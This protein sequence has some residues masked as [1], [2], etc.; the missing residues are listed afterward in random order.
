MAPAATL[1]SLLLLLLQMIPSQMLSKL[2]DFKTCGDPECARYLSRVTA[3]LDYT[4][5]DCRFLTFKHGDSIYVYFKLSG[6]RDDLWAGSIGK[7]FGYFPK[8][9]VKVDDVMTSTEVELPTQESDFLC[10]DEDNYHV[11]SEE[12]DVVIDEYG[13]NS[14]SRPEERESIL[15]HE[16]EPN[17][18]NQVYKGNSAK[19]EPVDNLIDLYKSQVQRTL[20]NTKLETNSGKDQLQKSL[21]PDETI[22]INEFLSPTNHQNQLNDESVSSYTDKDEF[23]QFSLPESVYSQHIGTTKDEHPRQGISEDNL[24]SM[25][26]NE[27]S[28][29]VQE[30]SNWI[31]SKINRWFGLESNEVK[32]MVE[33]TDQSTH[34]TS[35]KSRKIP[36][37]CDEN[38]VVSEEGNKNVYYEDKEIL[39]SGMSGWFGGLSKLLSLNS[40]LPEDVLSSNEGEKNNLENIKSYLVDDS[41]EPSKTL[42][43]KYGN[44][45]SEYSEADDSSLIYSQ[46]ENINKENQNL[47]SSVQTFF[48]LSDNL[49]FG[50]IN[51]AKNSDLSEETKVTMGKSRNDKSE[52][53][54]L[55]LNPLSGIFKFTGD[56]GGQIF[57]TSE[58]GN[59]RNP[60]NTG[61]SNSQWSH[62]SL[63]EMLGFSQGNKDQVSSFPD[64]IKEVIIENRKEMPLDDDGPKSQWVSISLKD[65]LMFGQTNEDHLEDTKKSA[66]RNKN[67]NTMNSEPV[68]SFS[69]LNSATSRV[70]SIADSFIND[71]PIQSQRQ[72][73]NMMKND[74]MRQSENLQQSEKEH[75]ETKGEGTK[76]AFSINGLK[77]IFEGKISKLQCV[78]ELQ[79]QSLMPN[80][81]SVGP[82]KR[83]T[84][85]SLHQDQS[86]QGHSIYTS[87]IKQCISDY[88]RT[89]NSLSG[90][91]IYGEQEI[92]HNQDLTLKVEQSSV[93]S[94]FA[95]ESLSEEV[96]QY[97]TMHF[98]KD[99]D[100]ETTQLR[101]ADNANHSVSEECQVEGE[102]LE[103]NL[104]CRL[105]SEQLLSN[106]SDP[107]LVNK[108]QNV[109][110]FSQGQVMNSDFQPIPFIDNDWHPPEKKM[111][112][113]HQRED[114]TAAVEFEQLD[115]SGNNK[116]LSQTQICNEQQNVSFEFN[117]IPPS[118][119]VKMSS[120]NDLHNEETIAQVTHLTS[121]K[122]QTFGHNNLLFKD[123][124]K[125]MSQLN[126]DDKGVTN[127]NDPSIEKQLYGETWQ[128]PSVQQAS[129]HSR[130]LSKENQPSDRNALQHQTKTLYSESNDTS[131]HRECLHEGPIRK[132]YQLLKSASN[133]LASDAEQ[134]FS[135][136]MYDEQNMQT[137]QT[138]CNLEPKWL[139]SSE[140]GEDALSENLHANKNILQTNGFI[141]SGSDKAKFLVKDK[142][143]D[144]DCVLQKQ[145]I[146][147]VL[148]SELHAISDDAESLQHGKIHIEEQTDFLSNSQP[149]EHA[150]LDDK[151][152]NQENSYQQKYIEDEGI[153]LELE[154]Q[155]VDFD[156]TVDSSEDKAT[157]PVININSKN[158]EQNNKVCSSLEP[159]TTVELL[160]SL[161]FEDANLPTVYCSKHQ[162]TDTNSKRQHDDK[163]TKYN[164][165]DYADTDNLSDEETEELSSESTSA[166]LQIYETQSNSEKLIMTE[167]KETSRLSAQVNGSPDAVAETTST[168][169][170]ETGAK[171]ESLTSKG[172]YSSHDTRVTSEEQISSDVLDKT[173]Q[174]S[175]HVQEQKGMKGTIENQVLEELTQNLSDKITESE[176]TTVEAGAESKL[177]NQ[178]QK[179]SQDI[180]NEES[181]YHQTEEK[182]STHLNKIKKSSVTDDPRVG[183]PTDNDIE[184]ETNVKKTANHKPGSIFDLGL[185]NL[186]MLIDHFIQNSYLTVMD[187]LSEDLGMSPN[188][189]GPCTEFLISVL[190]GII[191]ALLFVYRTCQAVK[192]RRYMGREKQLAERVSQ[193]FDEKCKVLETLSSCKQK[194]S[195]FEASV[196]NAAGLKEATE[197]NT[198]HLQDA[199]T[200]LDKSNDSIRQAI[201]QFTQDLEGEKQT[202]SRQSNLITK[203]Q[204][205]L[206]ALENEA[207]NLKIQ[208]EEA[209]KELKAIQINDARHQESS[210]AAKEEN[211]HLKQS[212]EQLLQES[213]GWNERYN[214]LTE[215][216]KLSTK[217]HKDIRDVLACKENEVKS[218]TDCLL[219]MKLWNQVEED[220][221]A[222]E[223]SE[224]QRK[225]KIEKLIHVAKVNASLKSVEEERNQIHS[226]LADETKAKQELMEPPPNT[227]DILQWLSN[228]TAYPHSHPTTTHGTPTSLVPRELKAADFVF[229]RRERIEKLQLEC[230]SVQ[231]VKTQ[232]ENEYKTIQQKLKIMTELYHEKEM[233]L[234]R[235]LTLE[236][237]QRLQKEDKLFEVDEK[238]NQATEE[239][240]IYRQ[241]AKDLEGELIKTMQS[242]KN[243]IVSHEKKAHDNWLS[244]REAERELGNIKRENIYL[245]QKII[246]AELKMDNAL[247][248]PLVHVSGRPALSA[249]TFVPAYR[250][251]SSPYGPSPVSRPGSEPVGFLSPPL[252][253]GPSR[254]SPLFPGKPD[255]KIRSPSVQLDHTTNENTDSISDR[256]SDQH[257]P[258]S[259]S[260]SLSPVW[261]RDRKLFRVSPDGYP[262]LENNMQTSNSALESHAQDCDILNTSRNQ[263]LPV[264]AEFGIRPNFAPVYRNQVPFFP[265][266]LRGHAPLRGPP[267]PPRVGIYGPP[268]RFPLR[269]FGLPP[270]PSM[271]IGERLQP[272]LNRIR[273]TFTKYRRLNLMEVRD[274]RRPGPYLNN[275]PAPRP[276]Y[277]PHRPFSDI[278]GGLL[279]SRLP[280][281]KF[282][283]TE[284]PSSQDK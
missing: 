62:F 179:K 245:R 203:I 86:L 260:G 140:Q 224:E 44:K 200:K 258:Q 96:E 170:P 82:N 217:S 49:W 202:K 111:H 142:L 104:V 275:F 58:D 186:T 60:S 5:R 212:K 187:A 80:S 105:K 180:T 125:E 210:Q 168:S 122:E 87:E 159:E 246:E 193:L 88:T 99:P 163:E 91:N 164:M 69:T 265:V 32:K 127:I 249:T 267:P 77:N 262:E 272:K 263:S 141:H 228:H 118:R 274:P 128:V 230:T 115:A 123:R 94:P 79:E 8:D 273:H 121:A 6:K 255:P 36:L 196:K 26:S 226:K 84:P 239:L 172:T 98:D 229:V 1:G 50:Q 213:E 134:P 52:S 216:I 147:A 153:Y 171:E 83:L 241:R 132:E 204:A 74:V 253:D 133:E 257:G 222:E 31:G 130:D 108:L 162:D 61:G 144:K 244:A 120:Q 119:Q 269:A 234:Q 55:N 19:A 43:T 205:N 199:Y 90:E 101:M 165:C 177:A 131:D 271:G 198:L 38:T 75:R 237:H 13:E 150:V 71:D 67:E 278:A 173:S 34:I 189:H 259:D 276:V 160:N 201:D 215:H 279:P 15:G 66:I 183:T 194:Y 95:A 219:K 145:C 284:H 207:Q 181:N 45:M 27:V 188:L 63:S 225:Q 72:D 240:A 247:K 175:N 233:E 190:L 9:A 143:N 20:Q 17:K 252:I 167:R 176:K 243:Q 166:I 264:E 218:L 182:S 251:R 78:Q 124:K 14:F 3:T 242:Y 266:N 103:D 192:S 161:S 256:M 100:S 197:A 268:E 28:E 209:K 57:R 184:Y 135:L 110:K 149:E 76:S 107:M 146:N 178:L 138:T 139:V 156:S 148:K 277:F 48:G 42:L 282:P 270:P 21:T 254:F 109:K 280:L 68:E 248:D 93:K 64:E 208:V 59:K 85:K 39:D 232:F 206:C 154:N 283:T 250:G 53:Q 40:D 97:L 157:A 195:E 227:L 37:D 114:V 54:W 231:C 102:V 12:N 22:Q 4:G 51:K 7:Q 112:H 214:E 185:Q 151:T 174:T 152:L 221:P 23:N 126:K 41:S 35:F 223:I 46:S 73:L 11:D 211:S 191:T 56:S 117:A 113:K 169:K 33:N 281:P 116:L 236:E 155:F 30:G 16:P 220:N 65:K 10:L 2:S 129:Y 25:E 137:K 29:F 136:K 158:T 18:N 47:M 24:I 89:K 70:A 235:N 261:E 238:M 92:L 81:Y 106:A